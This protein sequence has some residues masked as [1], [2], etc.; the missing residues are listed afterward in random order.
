MTAARRTPLKGW[1]TPCVLSSRGSPTNHH[2]RI[3]PQWGEVLTDRVTTNTATCFI[4]VA[5]DVNGRTWPEI[6]ERTW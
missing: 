4:V 5:V 3:D 1:V 2:W 6:V